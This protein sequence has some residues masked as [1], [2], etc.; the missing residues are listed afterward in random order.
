MEVTQVTKFKVA[1]STA[2][3]H[4]LEG[5]TAPGLCC[6]GRAQIPHQRDWLINEL[7]VGAGGLLGSLCDS[8][9]S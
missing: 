4:D 1:S 9:L 3:T 2:V 5:V 8:L 7:H 6:V